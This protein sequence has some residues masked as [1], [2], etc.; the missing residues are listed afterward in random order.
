MHEKLDLQETKQDRVRERQCLNVTTHT[1]RL[2]GSRQ[3]EGGEVGVST[4][5]AWLKLPAQP[6]TP[7]GLINLTCIR[8]TPRDKSTAH[9]PEVDEHGVGGERAGRRG[10]V[11]K[12]E[13][14]QTRL[15]GQHIS[16]T[17]LILAF[18]CRASC[19]LCREL[20]FP[21]SNTIHLVMFNSNANAA[22]SERT[23]QLFRFSLLWLWG[24]HSCAVC[25]QRTA[26][27]E[28]QRWDKQLGFLLHNQH[29]LKE[30]LPDSY[31]E[32]NRK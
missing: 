20:G 29:S 8:S 2:A 22:F 13:R 21:F 11:Q 26:V 18:M 24:Q 19:P 25:C 7:S 17:M 3:L 9:F 23:Y 12:G 28:S 14:N 5:P 6:L 16:G 1:N 30:I 4:V 27:S 31:G 10:T 15:A 32:M